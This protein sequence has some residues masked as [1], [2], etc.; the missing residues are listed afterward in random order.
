MAERKQ[1]TYRGY[2][3]E[4]F[5]EITGWAVQGVID[6]RH[7]F[8]FTTSA[9]DVDACLRHGQA[10]VDVLLAPKRPNAW[11]GQRAMGRKHYRRA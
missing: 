9:P 6:G 10:H 11:A 5:P 2:R 1:M 4:A 7:A 3:L 8:T